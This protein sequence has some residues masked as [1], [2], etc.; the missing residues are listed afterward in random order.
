MKLPITSSKI[1]SGAQATRAQTSCRNTMFRFAINGAGSA[2]VTTWYGL[3]AGDA[4]PPRAEA[5]VLLLCSEE[6]NA[7]VSMTLITHGI[8]IQAVGVSLIC[9]HVINCF[10]GCSK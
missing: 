8:A 4:N 10:L 1:S 7:T 5:A 3:N 9:G 2:A 6:Q